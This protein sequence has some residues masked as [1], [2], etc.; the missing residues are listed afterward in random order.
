MSA[1]SKTGYIVYFEDISEGWYGIT[2]LEKRIGFGLKWDKNIYRHL[3]MWQ[4]H[5]GSFG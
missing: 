4:I 1:E 5:R 2:N 3:W